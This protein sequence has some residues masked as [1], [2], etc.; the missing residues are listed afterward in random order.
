MQEVTGGLEAN[1]PYI[2]EPSADITTIIDFGENTLKAG[3][4]LSVG[5]GFTFK[6][7]YDR[8]KW[9]TDESDPLYDATRAAELGKAYGF[10][11]EEITVGSTK[12]LKGQFVKLGSGA[13]SRPFR[14]YMLYD[15]DW[16]GI[17]PSASAR[18][19]SEAQ[20][21]PDVIDIVWISAN[22]EATGIEDINRETTNCSDWYSLDG[23][24]LNGK[25]TVK[26]LYIN[27]GRKVVIQ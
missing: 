10:A 1:T 24:K 4:P 5:S 15:G 23:R 8:V 19:R 17:Q 18:N 21:L 14:A 13:H 12:Y 26:G 16:D 7:I 6:G 22:D 2:F 9:T 20:S 11:L 27:N 25:P 3:G